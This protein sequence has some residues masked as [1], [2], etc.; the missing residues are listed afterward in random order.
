MPWY[1]ILLILTSPLWLG[2][3]GLW[4]GYNLT[5]PGPNGALTPSKRDW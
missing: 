4:I 3:F 2:G 5:A 1:V